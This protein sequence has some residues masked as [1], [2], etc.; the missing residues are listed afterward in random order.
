MCQAS[1]AP[2]RPLA[3]IQ[4]LGVCRPS[5]P[6]SQPATGSQPGRPG[7]SEDNTEQL[8]QNKCHDRVGLQWASLSGLVSCFSFKPAPSGVLPV[9]SLWQILLNVC[10]SAE[11]G[12]LGFPGAGC[13]IIDLT[14]YQFKPLGWPKCHNNTQNVVIV[15]Y[16]AA[17]NAGQQ[18]QQQL[19][20]AIRATALVGPVAVAAVPKLGSCRWT[21]GRPG[22]AVR[23]RGRACRVLDRLLVLLRLADAGHGL[24]L[25]RV[26]TGQSVLATSSCC[27]GLRSCNAQH[28]KAH[29]LQSRV[30]IVANCG[31][32]LCV[33]MRWSGLPQWAT[34]FTSKVLLLDYW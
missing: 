1:L 14:I 33:C 21:R 34:G 3:K 15:N 22:C 16:T 12:V 30:L 26:W 29:V 17:H 27:L 5:W 7:S 18:Q 23:Q 8:L 31:M 6:A 20:V 28:P 13:H 10:L 9:A 32:Q 19:Q 11:C 4:G 25:A 24:Q 2:T